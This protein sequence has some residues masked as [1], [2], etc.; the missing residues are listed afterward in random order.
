MGVTSR[1][2]GFGVL[3]LVAV[4]LPLRPRGSGD[5]A[6]TVDDAARRLDRLGSLELNAAFRWAALTLRDSARALAPG[7]TGGVPPTVVLRGFPPGDSAPDAAKEI[8]AL[9]RAIPDPDRRVRV[10]LLLYDDTHAEFPTY[11]GTFISDS[12]NGVRCIA[13]TPA[14][15]RP[16]GTLGIFKSELDRALAPCALYAAFGPPGPTLAAWLAG[17]RYAPAGSVDWITGR[18]QDEMVQGPFAMWSNGGAPGR[19]IVALASMLGLDDIASILVPPYEFGAAG[20][21]CLNGDPE[22]CRT[23]VLFPDVMRWGDRDIPRDLTPPS[24]LMRP[25][26]ATLASVRPPASTYL[27]EMIGDFGRAR[28]RAFWASALPMDSAFARAF[29]EPLGEW[30][31][32]WARRAW[33]STFDAQYRSADVTLGVTLRPIAPLLATLWSAVALAVAS[34]VAYRRRVR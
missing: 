14:R 22:A 31:A 32:R 34:L 23:S 30:T 4:L 28:F 21:Q 27:A 5:S 16:R 8:A 11:F 17:T 9:W 25:D 10:Q 6:A 7:M 3:M 26:S 2:I 33:L 15:S 1:R 19:R 18:R 12:A 24:F 13:M 20:L 29:G